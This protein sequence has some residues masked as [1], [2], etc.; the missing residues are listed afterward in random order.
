MAF[1]LWHL[2]EARARAVM[3]AGCKRAGWNT[4]LSARGQGHG[5]GFA[6]YKGSGAYCA[7]VAEVEGEA[8]MG[9]R[10]VLAVEW[11]R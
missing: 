8:D 7:V 10:L 4:W 5:I 2:K 1:R 3:E 9:T 6:R 11:V